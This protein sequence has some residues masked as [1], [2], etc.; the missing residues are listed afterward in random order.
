MSSTSSRV[1]RPKREASAIS[2]A[3]H[4]DEEENDYADRGD[5]LPV[6]APSNGYKDEEMEQD[7]PYY[8]EL[9]TR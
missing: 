6:M 5:P 3:D 4:D 1:S 2:Y 8:R 9:S 7:D